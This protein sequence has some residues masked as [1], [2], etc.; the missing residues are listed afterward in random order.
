M[1][2]SRIRRAKKQYKID[3]V[4]VE[5]A[6]ETRNQLRA[7]LES[8]APSPLSVPI[9][10]TPRGIYTEAY[11]DMVHDMALHL[12]GQLGMADQITFDRD[13]TQQATGEF[14]LR[15][16]RAESM[17]LVFMRVDEH[18]SPSQLL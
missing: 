7:M 13:A 18:V 16:A 14:S 17:Q 12:L 15:Q 9:A 1:S 6:Y 3:R 4:V 5:S 8:D 10:P 11:V 2:I